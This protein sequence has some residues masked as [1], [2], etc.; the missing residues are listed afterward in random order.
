MSARHFSVAATI[1]FLLGG[2]ASQALAQPREAEDFINY[3]YATWFGTG[4][5]SV[6]DRDITILRAP[7]SIPIRKP[8]PEEKKWGWRLMLPVTLGRHEFDFDFGDIE[9]LETITFVPGVE[10]QVPI[11][12]NWQLKPFVQAGVGNDFSGGEFSV[13]YGTGLK[14]LVTFPWKKFIFG[15][16]NQLLFAGQTIPDGNNSKGFAMFEAGLDVLLPGSFK[17]GR[18]RVNTSVFGILSW[19]TNEVDF[20]EPGPIEIEVSRITQVGVS[21]GTEREFSFWKVKI[22]RLG[23]TYMDG[24][25]GFK[26]IRVNVGFPF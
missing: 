7:I 16:G 21:F 13:I 4:V 6:G 25:K 5:Y 19:F 14:S 26:G 1:V 8:V 12:E 22:P 15:V 23:V 20:L 24:D 17:L 3:A 10:F 18:R 11:R 2:T 9:D